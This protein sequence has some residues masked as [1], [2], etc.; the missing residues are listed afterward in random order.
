M[1]RGPRNARWP[2]FAEASADMPR[3]RACMLA[4]LIVRKR[5][6]NKRYKTGYMVVACRHAAADGDSDP[7]H[8]LG[9]EGKGVLRRLPRVHDRL[10]APLRRRL[11]ALRTGLARRPETAPERAPWRCLSRF[12]G[13]DLHAGHRRLSP[14]AGGEELPLL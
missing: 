8:L 5:F 10:G 6:K 2:A 3:R 13:A 1:T 4:T 9:R 7:A 14:R 12:D 11:P